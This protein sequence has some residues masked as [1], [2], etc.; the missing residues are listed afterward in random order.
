MTFLR[1]CGSYDGFIPTWFLDGEEKESAK[2]SEYLLG[3]GKADI[4]GYL[5]FYL[6]ELT[7]CTDVYIDRLSKST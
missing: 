2:G 1:Y 4:T 3:V 5:F 6:L 7:Q